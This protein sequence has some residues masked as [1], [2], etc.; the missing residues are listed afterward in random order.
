MIKYLKKKLRRYLIREH[1][2]P[3]YIKKEDK[4]LLNGKTALISGGSSGIGLAIAKKLK[5]AGCKVII[6]GRNSKK[7]EKA[8]NDFNLEYVVL[9]VSDIKET[10]L[11]ITEI[12][13][14]EKIDILIN[15]A[16]VHCQDKFGNVSEEA[17]DNVLDINVKGLYFLS[18]TI[19]NDMILK[20][21]KGHILNISSASSLK[22]S[23]TPYE[24]SKRAVDG[25]TQGMAHKLIAH[26]ITVNGIAPGPTATPMLL[27]EDEKKT[28]LSWPA[29]PSGR[30][31]TVEEIAELALFMVAGT[32]NGIVGDTVFLTGGSGTVRIDK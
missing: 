15:S 25:I 29:N 5:S 32:G 3:I 4:T 8:A 6:A 16:G 11:K 24:I 27:F 28:D 1:L 13:K 26:G 31:S 14:K 19:A 18:Q 7:L 9:N 23:W 22:P 2:V 10:N 21:I 17:W 30:V 20:N 12:S